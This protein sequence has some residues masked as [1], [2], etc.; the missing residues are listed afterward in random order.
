M[1]I[2]I[3][4]FLGGS[5]FEISKEEKSKTINARTITR[6]VLQSA[7][8]SEQSCGETFSF[9]FQYFWKQ[10]LFL[11]HQKNK[12]KIKKYR[13]NCVTDLIF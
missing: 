3:F 13:H 5:F 6:T 9:F 4:M 10:L 12:T 11:P 8:N 7:L 1:K 2:M